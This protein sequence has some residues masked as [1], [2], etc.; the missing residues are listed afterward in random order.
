MQVSYDLAVRAT[1][2]ELLDHPVARTLTLSD[3]VM[4]D[5]GEHGDVLGVE[6][7]V[8]P[9]D[10]TPEMVALVV[11]R[12]PMMKPLRDVETWTQPGMPRRLAAI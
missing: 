7:L 12:Y 8:L 11:D 3:S 10:I 2:V 4:V 1:Y 9:A 6:F 5:L